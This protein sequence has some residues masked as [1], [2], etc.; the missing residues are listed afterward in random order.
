MRAWR[1]YY[2]DGSTFCSSDGAPWESPEWGAVLI[3]QPEVHGMDTLSHGQPYFL[4]RS[5]LDQWLNCDYPGLMDQVVHF[6]QHIDC[7]RVGRW[8]P[9]VDW[10]ALCRR[11]RSEMGGTA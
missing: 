2:G 5:D 9:T 6:A 11:A 1:I 8:Q 7:V 3:T 10:Q 4:H